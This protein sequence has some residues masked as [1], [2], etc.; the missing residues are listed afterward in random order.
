MIWAV[1]PNIKEL[2]KLADMSGKGKQ[3]Y[4]IVLY[5]LNDLTA[6]VL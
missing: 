5:Q 2:Q 6:Q 1:N 3:K 4:L